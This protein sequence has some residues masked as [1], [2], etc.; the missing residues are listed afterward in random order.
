MKEHAC[1]QDS[2]AVAVDGQCLEG[3]LPNECPYHRW[4]EVPEESIEEELEP[5]ESVREEPEVVFGSGDFL[6]ASGARELT[7]RAVSRVIVLAGEVRSGKT[8]I[9]ASLM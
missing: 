6:D 3:L 5:L 4:L 9:L 1:A 8:A 2:C 7:R